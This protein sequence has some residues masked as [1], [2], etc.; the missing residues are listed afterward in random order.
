MD[1]EGIVLNKQNNQNTLLLKKNSKN[2]DDKKES[3]P[4]LNK[5]KKLKR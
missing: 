3:L 1:F 4:D 5:G 2:N